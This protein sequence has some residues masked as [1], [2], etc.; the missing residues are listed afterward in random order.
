MVK[1]ITRFFARIKSPS[2]QNSLEP[3]TK[4][5]TTPASPQSRSI[6]VNWYNGVGT[7]EMVLEV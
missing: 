5:G 6:L 7:Q 3:K 4:S 2:V 1:I